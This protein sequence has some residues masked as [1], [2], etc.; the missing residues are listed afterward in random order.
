MSQ[1]EDYTVDSKWTRTQNL[2]DCT[3][4]LDKIGGASNYCMHT[5]DAV[6]ACFQSWSYKHA[7]R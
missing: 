4:K 7:R 3:P 5:H 2:A 1:I 6:N